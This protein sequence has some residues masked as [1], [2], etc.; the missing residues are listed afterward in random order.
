MRYHEFHAGQTFVLGPVTMTQADIIAFATR[1]DPQ[2]FHTDPERAANGRWQG[3]IASGWHTCAVAMRLVVEGP[4]Q[5]FGS[6]GSPGLAYLRW[7]AP[8]RPD[9][10][11]SVHLDVLETRRSG[12]GRMGSVR[13]QW[14]VRNQSGTV[15]METE[16]TSLFELAEP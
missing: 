16:A 14:Q 7:K 8:V 10:A 2:W 1:W 9:D 3:L 15:V 5:D 13:W 12:G 6:I 4:L 11:L